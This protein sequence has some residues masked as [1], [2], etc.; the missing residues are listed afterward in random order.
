[1]IKN[2]VKNMVD[3][4]KFEGT[5]Q[6]SNEGNLVFFLIKFLETNE[7]SKLTSFRNFIL[8]RK[9]E[10]PPKIMISNWPDLSD[11]PRYKPKQKDFE[12]V[13]KVIWQDA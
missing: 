12:T 4:K 1:M 6:S 7:H 11:V 5:W 9:N 2:I 3:Q 8:N 10:L 13:I